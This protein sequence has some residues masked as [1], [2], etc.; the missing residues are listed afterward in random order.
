MT[1]TTLNICT[2]LLI[3]EAGKSIRDAPQAEL[4]LPVNAILMKL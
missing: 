3:N 2:V 1:R 4:K